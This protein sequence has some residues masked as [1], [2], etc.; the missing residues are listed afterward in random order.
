M[1]ELSQG[2]VFVNLDVK[3]YN[4][5]CYNRVVLLRD[6]RPKKGWWRAYGTEWEGTLD[7]TARKWVCYRCARFKIFSITSTDHIRKHLQK[8][9]HIFEGQELAPVG[10]DRMLASTPYFEP[11][12]QLDKKT[13]RKH[14]AREALV[15]WI[16]YDHIVFA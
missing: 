10:I 7:S 16:C 15:N 13:L 9:H 6:K 11:S 2:Q 3:W 12:S 5:I 14:L 8:D 1:P 4:N